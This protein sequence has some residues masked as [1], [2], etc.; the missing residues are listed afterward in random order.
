MD[1]LAKSHG[2][3]IADLHFY[4]AV[5]L[6]RLDRLDEATAEYTEELADFPQNT[7]ASTA[8]AALYH[9]RGAAED[10]ERVVTEMIDVTPTPETYALAARLWTTFGDSRRAAVA[11]GEARKAQTEGR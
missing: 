2:Q 7:R 3:P 6:A 1:T 10:A 5:T 8:L 4:A 9:T 11:R